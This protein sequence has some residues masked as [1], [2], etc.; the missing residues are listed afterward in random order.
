M[1][2]PDTG[3]IALHGDGTVTEL[4]ADVAPPGLIDTD[5]LG[6]WRRDGRGGLVA[7]VRFVVAAVDA[8]GG[9]TAGFFVQHFRL[10]RSGRGLVGEYGWAMVD[11]AG[12]TLFGGSGPV[13]LLPL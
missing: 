4:L 10:R 2:Q 13:E 6:E 3:L 8:S 11:L 5:G 1:T 12:T 7:T 9:R